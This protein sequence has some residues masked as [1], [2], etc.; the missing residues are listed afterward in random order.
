VN[1]HKQ[2]KRSLWR[3]SLCELE[4]PCR[5]CEE[6]FSSSGASNRYRKSYDTA[7]KKAGVSEQFREAIGG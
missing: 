7:R 2:T 4:I 5:S 1:N 6:L 3:K